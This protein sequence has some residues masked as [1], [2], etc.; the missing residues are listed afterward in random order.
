MALPLASLLLAVVF[1]F[2]AHV[3]WLENS[4]RTSF[5][6]RDFVDRQW[7]FNV[8]E[9][10]HD[11]FDVQL[12]SVEQ[13]PQEFEVFVCFLSFSC[14]W[15]SESVATKHGT[16]FSCSAAPR[17]APSDIEMNP[18]TDLVDLLSVNASCLIHVCMFVSVSLT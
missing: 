3:Y 13:Q 11:R 10:L 9:H 8:T 16:L 7:A 4:P 17:L 6:S 14:S 5:V 2:L 15:Q 18:S 12:R 1:G